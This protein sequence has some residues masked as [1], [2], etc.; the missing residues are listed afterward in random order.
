MSCEFNVK[1]QLKSLCFIVSEAALLSRKYSRVSTLHQ[2]WPCM[3]MSVIIP[4]W[5]SHHW[6]S[7]CNTCH[8]VV[9]S[10]MVVNCTAQ[11]LC[12]F[13]MIKLVI[14]NIPD[15]NPKIYFVVTYSNPRPTLPKLSWK[16]TS[17]CLTNSA[18]IDHPT[19]RKAKTQHPRWRLFFRNDFICSWNLIHSIVTISFSTFF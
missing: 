4:Y 17:N 3:L 15:L 14:T 9:A 18:D 16:F 2:D 10:T 7:H 19:D 12:A 11:M 8:I 1:H 13:T 5:I 6:F